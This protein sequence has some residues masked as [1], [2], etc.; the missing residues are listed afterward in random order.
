M[1]DNVHVEIKGLARLQAAFRAFPKQVARN[2]SQAVHEAA[3]DVI[4]P[5][6][7]LQRYP[8]ATDANRPP[9]PYYKRGTGMQT[10]KSRNLMNSEN[11]G[12]QWYVRRVG[13]EGKIGNRASYAKWVHGDP[14]EGEG[15]AREMSQ[16]AKIP[17]GWRILKEVADE[18]IGKITSVYSNWV[19]KTLRD[20]GL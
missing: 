14:K 2:I 9:T 1:P 6:K 19:G 15:Q 13:A 5:T 16:S 8:P 12:K 20:L 7:G 11:L 3:K 10:S 18:K 17:K 4:L